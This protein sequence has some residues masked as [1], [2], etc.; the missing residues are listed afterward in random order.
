VDFGYRPEAAF[1]PR[2]GGGNYGMRKELS[3]SLPPATPADRV[4]ALDDAKFGRIQGARKM[5]KAE[6]LPLA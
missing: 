1:R 3:T 4:F 2:L 6:G 5:T